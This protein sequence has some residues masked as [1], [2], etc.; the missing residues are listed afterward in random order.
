MANR[1]SPKMLA[2]KQAAAAGP[3][4]PFDLAAVKAANRAHTWTRYGKPVAPRF[5]P[6]ELDQLNALRAAL[7]SDVAPYATRLSDAAIVKACFKY[8]CQKLLKARQQRGRA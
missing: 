3:Q 8:A 6:E 2:S 7:P 1:P 5:L 4:P